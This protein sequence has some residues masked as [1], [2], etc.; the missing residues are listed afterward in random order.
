MRIEVCGGIASGKTT[1]AAAM[2]SLG[3]IPCH[4]RFQENPFLTKFYADLPAY[5]FETEITYL[6]Q[7][8]SQIREALLAPRLATD[9][10]LAL[11][12]AYAYVTL[13]PEDQQTFAAVLSRVFEKVGAP[14]LIVRLECDSRVELDRIQKRNRQPE[15]SISLEYLD[16][17]D[18]AIDRALES[19]WFRSVPVIRIDSHRADFRVAGD[20][21]EPVLQQIAAS[22]RSDTM[23]ADA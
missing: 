17:L 15:Q 14:S 5:A 16:A 21:R 13:Q 4:E 18:S 6:L 10:S 20:G 3:L 22:L 23:R 2:A 12:L 1:L 19:R 7:H 11:D 8:Y 9:F